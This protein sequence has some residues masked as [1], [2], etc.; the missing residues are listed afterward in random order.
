MAMGITNN[1]RHMVRVV[2]HRMLGEM[3]AF[4]AHH[5]A[6]EANSTPEIKS[7]L[8]WWAGVSQSA[9][10]E[11]F[12]VLATELGYTVEKF[13]EPKPA[14]RIEDPLFGEVSEETI[15]IMDDH[16]SGGRS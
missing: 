12:K 4:S 10:D 13:N 16:F 2:L 8:G 15:R 11:Q 7:E 5:L 14:V 3:E 9:F 1:N 6:W